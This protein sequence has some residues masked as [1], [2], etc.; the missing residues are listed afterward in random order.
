[1][2]AF[3]DRSIKKCGCCCFGLHGKFSIAFLFKHENRYLDKQLLL[4]VA[5]DSM[6][7]R[8]TKFNSEERKRETKE[9][10]HKKK[11]GKKWHQQNSR[12]SIVA[13]EFIEC[14]NS[15]EVT[16]PIFIATQLYI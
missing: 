4:F 6:T 16:D 10:K 1:M 7:E 15:M 5:L 3:H 13:N 12:Q 9:E 14:R 11:Q 2:P 8:Q